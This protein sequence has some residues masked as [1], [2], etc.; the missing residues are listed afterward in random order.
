MDVLSSFPGQKAVSKPQSLTFSDYI[1][2]GVTD[3]MLD[4]I[5]NYI[6][7]ASGFYKQDVGRNIAYIKDQL[8]R[9][10]GSSD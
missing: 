4:D 5:K 2:A 9:Q 10:Y 3:D 1:G 8:D 6:N 7:A